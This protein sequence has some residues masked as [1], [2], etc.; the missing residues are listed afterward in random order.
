MDQTTWKS[1]I[2]KFLTAQTISLF[3][4]SIV[5]YAIIWH[6]TLTT[7]SGVMMTIA[8]IC[9]YV[10]QIV[11]SLFAGVW[12]DRYD[13]KKLMMISDAMI[14]VSTFIIAL[15]FISGY[16]EIW[17]LF[18]VLIVRSAGT[19][20]Q[21]PAVNAFIPELVPKEHLMKVN[22]INSTLNSLMIFLSPAISGTILSLT[23]IEVTFFIDVVTAI[24]G[25]SIMFTIKVAGSIKA[26]QE[27]NA[28]STIVDIK[29]GFHYL[30]NHKFIKHQIIY[31]MVV[32]VLI[33]PS[34]FL[35]PLLVSRAFGPEVWRLTV[36]QMS[37][38]FGA[39]MGGLLITTWG[40]FR[41]RRK[42]IIAATVFYGAM[43]IGIGFSPVY[44]VYILFN[45]LIGISMPCYNAPVNVSLQENVEHE[46]QGRVFSI[47]Q[48][49]NACALPLG[50]IIFGPMADIISVQTIL[51]FTGS[52]VVIFALFSLKNKNFIEGV[53]DISK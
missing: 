8:T 33:S 9:G 20:L 1:K 14:A 4:S 32:A 7:S 38:S 48:I 16:R 26:V 6:I 47:V 24:I 41:N 15:S 17:L 3:G 27:K 19:G 51:L 23:S 46:M 40:G 42:T 28:V 12:L 52:A 39:V 35:T 43:M 11:I 29:Q 45:M 37:F 2:I 21:T 49:A 31:L 25:I 10:P 34:A 36:S 50:T 22:G 44:F 5:Q 13:K 30:K 18:A 53:N